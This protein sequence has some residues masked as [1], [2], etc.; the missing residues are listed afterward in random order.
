VIRKAYRRIAQANHP[1]KKPGDEAVSIFNAATAAYEV[2]IDPDQRAIYDDFG[3]ARF[4][5]EWQYKEAQRS[6]KVSKTA[7]R[8]FY[9]GSEDVQTLT[10]QN[11]DSLRAPRV[12]YMYASWCDHCVKFVGG[13]KRTAMLLEGEVR[14]GA[15][16]C[17]KNAVLC[18]RLGVMSYPTIR[19]FGVDGMA[20][21]FHGQHTSEDLFSWV[22][23]QL[24]DNVVRLTPSA[25]ASSVLA[26]TEPWLVDFSAG[27]WCGPCTAAKSRLKSLATQLERR[28]KVGLVDCDMHRDFCMSSGIGYYPFLKVYGHDRAGKELVFG[29]NGMQQ[30][31][32]ISALDSLGIIADALL[33][34]R[35]TLCVEECKQRNS[36][37]R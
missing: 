24:R 19:F 17:E 20:E 6:G 1:D 37:L 10:M 27:A 18:Q 3:E 34:V 21:D 5:S 11:F 29:G 30:F 26:S 14:F 35:V 7:Q 2:L 12:V 33:P 8:D 4:Q 25:F 22:K 15:V 31:P 32:V 16:N 23:L 13:Y 28:V 36:K 9:A